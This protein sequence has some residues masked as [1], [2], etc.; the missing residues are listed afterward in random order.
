M[1]DFLL[2][3]E[4]LPYAISLGLVLL[5]GLLET[6]S[7]V[8]GASLV[9]LLHPAEVV[10]NIE[11]SNKNS[12]VMLSFA[13]WLSMNRLPVLLW[14]ALALLSFSMAGF[15]INAVSMRWLLVLQP[16]LVSLPFALFLMALSCHYF[17][18]A[19]AD[20]LQRNISNVIS[21][22][23]L[24]GSVAKLEFGRAMLGYPGAA[25]VV[26]KNQQEHHVFVE[27][28]NTEVEFTEGS[29]VVL[30]KRKGRVWQATPIDD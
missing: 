6:L 23:D 18:A 15:V 28:V 12:S 24:N 2:S 27:P 26:D 7:L 21:I 5:F 19:I 22:E 11:L 16:Q 29:L 3:Q 4:N 17:G 25:I 14:F 1:V 13:S 20:R 8:I 9:G 10:D 30:V